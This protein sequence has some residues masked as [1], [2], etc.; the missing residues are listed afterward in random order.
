MDEVAGAVE[1]ETVGGD[2]AAQPAG[3]VFFLQYHVWLFE[4]ISAGKPGYARSDDYDRFHW[5][6]L[7]RVWILDTG[8]WIL[9]YSIDQRLCVV[10][11]SSI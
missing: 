6:Q 11:F 7:L 1:G 4:R 5:K 10:D 3:F 9:D 2:G 8:S